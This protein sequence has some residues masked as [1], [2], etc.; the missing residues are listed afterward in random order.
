MEKKKK[1]IIQPLMMRR[2]YDDHSD[3]DATMLKKIVPIDYDDLEVKRNER[4]CLTD[5]DDPKRCQ[6]NCFLCDR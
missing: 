1:P 4:R 5:Y 6:G 3:R 2:D